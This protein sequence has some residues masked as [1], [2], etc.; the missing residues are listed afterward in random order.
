MT[1]SFTE[2][3]GRKEHQ[4]GFADIASTMVQC[5]QTVLPYSAAPCVSFKEASRPLAIWEVFGSPANWSPMEREHLAPY[6][7]I[8][9]D[10]AGN[11][12]C[13]E[14]VS[15]AVLL[16]DHEDWFRT[17][18]FINSGVLQLGECLLSYMG[19]NDGKRFRSA[20]EM[21][22]PPAIV[23]GSF[24]WHEAAALDTDAGLLN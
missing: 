15:G 21:I 14:Q 9:S 1:E 23:E 24:W 3:W 8:G 4:C 12:I 5:G 20:V 22:D 18:Q 19:E 6:R 7:M 10:G 2:R 11:P 16:L 13:V 17:V